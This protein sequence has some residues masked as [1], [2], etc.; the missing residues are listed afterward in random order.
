MC[1]QHHLSDINATFLNC[2]GTAMALITSDPS[3]L[4]EA[5]RL[6]QEVRTQKGLS[7]EAMCKLLGMSQNQIK[8]IEE[9]DVNYF[10]KNTTTLTWHARIYA[11]KIGVHLPESVFTGVRRHTTTP[12]YPVQMIPAFLLKSPSQSQ[13][14]ATGCGKR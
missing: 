5:G 2:L 8:A 10:K 7:L 1:S 12:S 6:L 3:N 14:E 13:T 9:G 11:K 4:I